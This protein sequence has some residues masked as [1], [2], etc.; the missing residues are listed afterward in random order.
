MKLRFKLITSLALSSLLL[1]SCGLG[2]NNKRKKLRGKSR[3]V[4]KIM[5]DRVEGLSLE[6]EIS[7]SVYRHKNKL[8]KTLK[9]SVEE[10]RKA[11]NELGCL[12]QDIRSESCSEY[13]YPRG[14]RIYTDSSNS[15]TYEIIWDD[16]SVKEDILL[17]EIKQMIKKL[18]DTLEI[19]EGGDS[20]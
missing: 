19:D 14:T 3:E 12:E 5:S 13:P 1:V 15:E 16:M 9:S 11:I 7:C 20:I 18:E 2:E 4:T 17:S 6:E 10:R 8:N